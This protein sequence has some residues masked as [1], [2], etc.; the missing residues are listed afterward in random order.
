MNERIQQLIDYKTGGR[1]AAFADMMGWSPQYLNKLLKDGGIGLRPIV[2]LLDRFSDIDARWLLLGE[3]T[4]IAQGHDIVRDRIYTL[5]SLDK[6]IPIM[7]TEEVRK[8]EAGDYSHTQ[9]DIARWENS[10]AEHQQ[11]T[12]EK[13]MEIQRRCEKK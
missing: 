7:T 1:K 9:E 3:G 2:A 12:K 4:M 5:L 6:Y 13:F 10:L 11:A 8:I